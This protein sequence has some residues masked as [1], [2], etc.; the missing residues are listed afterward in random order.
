MT[1]TSQLKPALS[2]VMEAVL[3]ESKNIASEMGHREVTLEHLFLAFM[4]I[5]KGAAYYALTLNFGIY[6]EEAMK[7]MSEIRPSGKDVPYVGDPAMNS[8][9]EKLVLISCAHAYEQKAKLTT[10]KH[11]LRMLLNK[12]NRVLTIQ[13]LLDRFGTN[14]IEVERSLSKSEEDSDE[15]L[16]TSEIQLIGQKIIDTGEEA[17]SI[18]KQIEGLEIALKEKER[19]QKDQIQSLVR[20]TTVNERPSR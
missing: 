8:C 6:F 4:K 9:V 16:W 15:E 14:D 17:N 18:R 1:I 12:G 3:R 2:P 13:I 11:V 19:K 7:S 5:N 20:L 10:T